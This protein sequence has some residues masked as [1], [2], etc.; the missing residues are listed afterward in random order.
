MP[1]AF[2]AGPYL[3]MAPKP[4]LFIFLSASSCSSFSFF[5]LTFSLPFPFFFS[6]S[7]VFLMFL[8][9]FSTLS[10]SGFPWGADSQFRAVWPEREL[11]SDRP[12]VERKINTHSRALTTSIYKIH[13][14]VKYRRNT[15]TLCS[16]EPH[17]YLY[18]LK[19]GF[20]SPGYFKQGLRLGVGHTG[21]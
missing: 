18:P 5:S 12:S 4:F 2:T 17:G 8:A 21:C 11:L 19:I 13:Q 16:A 20:L 14:N 15:S 3:S 6:F 1:S 10:S 7:F 9:F